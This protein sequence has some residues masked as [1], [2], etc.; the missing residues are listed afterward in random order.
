MKRSSSRRAAAFTILR[1]ACFSF[2]LLSYGRKDTVILRIFYLQVCFLVDR[3]P[4]EERR[5]SAEKF[6]FSQNQNDDYRAALP[7]ICMA[8]LG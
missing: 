1:V 7:F 5:E 3:K 2:F 6:Y 8:H 4:G